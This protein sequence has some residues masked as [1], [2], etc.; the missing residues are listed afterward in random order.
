MCSVPVT[1][2]TSSPVFQENIRPLLSQTNI[3]ERFRMPIYFGVGETDIAYPNS[4]RTLAVF[5]DHGIRTFPCSVPMAM[6][7]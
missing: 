5:N 2:R 3:H 7:G 4:M 1:G 6:N